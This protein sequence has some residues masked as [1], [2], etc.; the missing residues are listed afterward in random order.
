[1]WARVP[2]VLS[3]CLSVCA[4]G[5]GDGHSPPGPVQGCGRRWLSPL[6]T[7]RAPCDRRCPH[8]AAESSRRV[9]T[10]CTWVGCA[11]KAC[12]A[13]LFSALQSRAPS[14]H[15]HSGTFRPPC[16]WAHPLRHFPRST[17]RTGSQGV[18]SEAG[19]TAVGP[20]PEDEGS[21]GQLLPSAQARGPRLSGR[22]ERVRT[23]PERPDGG[24]GSRPRGGTHTRAPPGSARTRASWG[25][26]RPWTHRCHLSWP[27]LRVGGCG[28]VGPVPGD[29]AARQ[30]R[31][32]PA[33]WGDSTLQTDRSH[34][35]SKALGRRARATVPAGTGLATRP[36][37]CPRSALL[38]PVL[39]AGLPGPAAG[40]RDRCGRVTGDT[41]WGTKA[42]GA[43]TVLLAS[44]TAL[45]LGDGSPRGTGAC[46]RRGASGL[47]PSCG[48]Q[49]PVGPGTAP[50][51]RT[52]SPGHAP[53]SCLPGP[54]VHL[55]FRSPTAT[56]RGLCTMCSVPVDVPSRPPRVT[57]DRVW[58]TAGHSAL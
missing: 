25:C 3:V 14:P 15:P 56:H 45:R 22:A 1:M 16:L 2:R 57:G 8:T 21:Q 20:G 12:S 40:G 32:W 55:S 29:G 33:E 50:G 51:P 17:C 4:Q 26:A 19:G 7:V 35:P 44:P 48:T 46:V 36:C 47:T 28:G 34:G 18:G 10:E 43:S 13:A 39:G 53:C 31:C 6:L 49:R 5:S 24:L 30:P 42:G 27:H 41:S 37:P 52:A 11:P 54:R 23:S 9:E 58:G 38:R